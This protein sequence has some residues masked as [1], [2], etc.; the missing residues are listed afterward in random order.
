MDAP[1]ALPVD[2]DEAASIALEAFAEGDFLFFWNENQVQDLEERLADHEENE[3]LF[4]RLFP[5]VGG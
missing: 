1:G 4:V 3:A 2:E 5:L